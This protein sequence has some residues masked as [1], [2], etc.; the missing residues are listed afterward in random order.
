MF[1]PEGSR[2]QDSPLQRRN[3]F[4]LEYPQVSGHMEA[5]KRSY[6]DQNN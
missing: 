2:A 1:M 6:V 5:V 4:I 3:V